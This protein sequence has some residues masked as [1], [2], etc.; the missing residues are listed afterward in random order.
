MMDTWYSNMVLYSLD[1]ETFYDTNGDG[2][3]DLKG[4]KEKL[5]YL[6]GLGITC[7][8]IQPFYPSPNRDNGYDVTDYYGI[9]PKLG[10]HGIFSELIDH[11]RD[12]GIRVIVDLVV[13]HTSIA[14]PWFKAAR[15]DKHSEYRDYYVWSDEP[16]DFG[17]EHL[18][19]TGEENT[20]WTYDEEAGQYYLHRFYKEQPDL[21]IGNPA[22]RQE[23]LQIIGFWLKMGV[24]G[25]RI[26]AATLLIEPY[27][28]KD[29][30]K[31]DL[32]S[33]IAEMRDYASL[34][35]GDVILLGEAN[36][37]PSAMKTYMD[38]GQKMHMLFN[39]YM[40]MK[41]F[42]SLAR[43]SARPLY[44][45]LSEQTSI[46]YGNQLLNFLRNH[47]ELALDQLSED[48]QHEIFQA[49]APQK[50]MQLYGHGIRRRLAPMFGN[51]Q[52]RMELAFSLI[53]TL[54]GVPMI[55]YGD[56]IGMGDNLRLKGRNS[57]RTPMQWSTGK[58]GGF[59]PADHVNRNVI[60]EAPYDPK[61]V[62]VIGAY[63]DP[64]SL[65]NFMKRLIALRKQ[66]ALIG[67]AP[68]QAIK[69]R[70]E[71]LFAHRYE[72][73]TGLQLLLFHNLTDKEISVSADEADVLADDWVEIFRDGKTQVAHREI[74]LA[75]YGY[76]WMKK[77]PQ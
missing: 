35:K 59:S 53:F 39:F 26:D 70:H 17:E 62:N 41:L 15:K 57:V 33:F 64:D 43:K 40:N 8:W 52:C 45:A 23:I 29:G 38:K 72:D 49:F 76:L 58:H 20:I 12:L 63:R 18:K 68:V 47:D 25:F 61:H 60:Q 34:R 51:D 37:P 54:P 11:A 9:D 6:A 66:C 55:R 7:I 48:E 44:A 74:T 46:P 19:L 14:H 2:I 1:P 71:G 21:N 16:W 32:E 31:L 50:R 75:A 69:V 4:I 24:S 3:G 10:D 36:V 77:F 27:G 28:L 13:N 67:T 30:E 22:V 73:K 42:L 56:E 5:N 65:L